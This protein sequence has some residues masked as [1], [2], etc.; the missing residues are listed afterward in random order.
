MKLKSIAVAVL[1]LL[2]VTACE[3]NANPELIG[4]L[5]D[6]P[7]FR[8]LP[9][10][11]K[12][13][14]LKSTSDYPVEIYMAE[15]YTTGEGGKIGKTVFFSNTGNKKWEQDFVPF[16]N[17]AFDGNQDITYYIDDN[18]PKSDVDIG[19]SSAAIERAMTTWDNITCSDFGL[20]QIASDGRPTGYVANT[21]GYPGG[22]A[23]ADVTHCG[24]MEG[25]FFDIL[26]PGSSGF[27]LG[28]TFTLIFVDG[29][30]VP[31]DIDNNKKYDV[32]F[33]EIYFN[34]DFPWGV[35]VGEYY[36]IETVALHEAG[37]GLSQGHFGKAF[38][39]PKNGKLHFSPRA[40]MNAAYS[41]IQTEIL[42]T[43]NAGH[44]SIWANW[45]QN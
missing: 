15:Y 30:G 2:G 16:D 37:H 4:P 28:V 44:C 3:K 25:A 35:G 32:A 24:W 9:V 5:S 42:K 41:G 8:E 38:R 31:T 14:A 18:R 21:L 26:E 6:E 22:Y 11:T 34:D 20:T 36:D 33:R 40:A 39:T 29:S 7:V 13:S 12:S 45:P 10:Q 1:L 43:D 27:I 19:A 17:R 23:G